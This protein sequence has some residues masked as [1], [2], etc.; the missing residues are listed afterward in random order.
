VFDTLCF[1]FSSVGHNDRK[2]MK[3]NRR[4]SLA[5]KLNVII[6]SEAG[7]HQFYVLKAPD[8]AGSTVQ[9]ILKNKDK[10]ME[11]RKTATLLNASKLQSTLCTFVNLMLVPKYPVLSELIITEVSP[12]NRN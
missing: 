12:E 8:L 6:H 5:V 11:F 7:E 10:S 4:M 2:Q 1:T 3:K 9:S